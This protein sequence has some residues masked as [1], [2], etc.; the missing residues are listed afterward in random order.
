MY[1]KLKERKQQ[2]THDKENCLMSLKTRKHIDKHILDKH[3][4]LSVCTISEEC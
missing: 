3:T 2:V 1:N 4:I